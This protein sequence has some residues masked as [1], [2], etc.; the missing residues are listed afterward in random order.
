M[1]AGLKHF[2]ALRGMI[3]DRRI[4]MHGV[5]IRIGQQIVE[6]R[7]AFFHAKGVADLVHLVVVAP[8]DGVH[9]RHWDAADR[10]G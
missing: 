6:A 10:S 3:G 5:D 8:A 2:H 9:R 7:V 1:L 4:D